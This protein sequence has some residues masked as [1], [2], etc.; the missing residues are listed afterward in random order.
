MTNK[1]TYGAA[2]SRFRRVPL[3]FMLLA[4]AATAEVKLPSLYSSHMVIQRDLPV[5]VRGRADVG[6]TVS[7]SFRGQTR[8][9]VPDE[10]GQWEVALPPGNAGGPFSLEV[11]GANTIQLSDILVGDVWVASGQSNMEFRTEG[12]I[13]AEEE[14]R[15]ADRPNIRLFH[16]GA[17]SSTYPLDDLTT[18]MTWTACSPESAAHFSAV[19]FFFGKHIQDD[20]KVPIGLIEADW[21]AT[22]AEAWTSMRALTADASLMPVFTVWSHEIDGAAQLASEMES[23][24]RETALAKSQGKP[25][26]TFPAHPDLERITKKPSVIYN[27]MI[28]PLTHFPIRGVIWYQ[29]ESNAGSG[30]E[31]IYADLFQALIRDW[32]RSWGIGDFPFL[33][34]QIANFRAGS[35]A[36]AWPL[37]REARRQTLVL[38]NTAMAVTIDIGDP[39]NVHPKNK[40]DVGGRLALAARAVAYGEPIEYSGPL[41]R[42]LSR[43]E[44]GVR[45][46]FDHGNGLIAKGGVL[47]GFEIAGAD[48]RY[49]P[50]EARIDGQTVI[51]TNAAVTEPV[52]VRYSWK[53]NPDGNLYNQ[54]GLPASPFRSQ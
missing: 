53:D 38:K 40:Q 51:V 39:A 10:V 25:L 24:N 16:V 19:A 52:F 46:W 1:K 30:R 54:A 44:L 35:A 15:N 43:E 20:Q 34:V 17:A 2:I 3:L 18:A 42:M 7:V 22:A 9:A 26:P 23:E 29:G 32:R 48:E 49:F 47:R 37:V 8:K 5:I 6:E 31:L 45:I 36:G 13:N 50:A 21:G 28:A 41:F 11:Q 27:A 12:V 14:L 33:F 4:S